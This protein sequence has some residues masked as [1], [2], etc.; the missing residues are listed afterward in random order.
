MSFHVFFLIDG[1][2]N[3]IHQPSWEPNGFK[4]A[5]DQG[6]WSNSSLFSRWSSREKGDHKESILGSR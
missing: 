5:K 2:K 1:E 4:L 3:R 6:S